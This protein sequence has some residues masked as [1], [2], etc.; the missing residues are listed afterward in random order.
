[1]KNLQE[2]LMIRVFP[3]SG[4]QYESILLSEILPDWN[5]ERLQAF[6]QANAMEW[7][8]W[9]AFTPWVRYRY[10]D[11][12][13]D[14]GGP[15]LRL[16]VE[17]NLGS[18]SNGLLFDTEEVDQKAK[19][20]DPE[21]PY[22]S[23]D[24]ANI[25]EDFGRN[26][27]IPLTYLPNSEDR[28]IEVSITIHWIR[29]TGIDP[30]EVDLVVDL[31][32]TRTVALLLE[33][34]S[35]EP[36]SFGRRV[37]PVRFMPP[38]ETFKV[39]NFNGSGI[40][41]DDLSIIDS[42]FVLKR[43][44]FA[45]MEPPYGE[46]KVLRVPKENSDPKAETSRRKILKYIANTFVEMSP[47]LIGGGDFDG[48][49]RKALA[50]A[51]LDE[52]ARFTMGSPKRYAWD[53]RSVGMSGSNYWSQM[54]NSHG[55]S[56]ERPFYFE[57][58]D[59][60]FRLFMDPEGQ[61]W[62]TNGTPR[63][64]DLAHAPFRNSP[65]NFPRRDSI[66]WFALSILEAA[67]RQ[68]NSD[69]Y[70]NV[71]K[72]RTLPRKLARVSVLYPSGWTKL[73]K[74]AYFNQWKRAMKIFTTSHLSGN[75]RIELE[76]RD[77]S[78]LPVFEER[79]LDEA[80]CA[81]LP[82]VYSE[83]C[84]LGGAGK[85]WFDLYGNGKKVRVM[86]VDIGGGTTDFSVIEYR[87]D[88]GHGETPETLRRNDPTARLSAKLWYK[89]GKSIAGDALV[90][91][92]IEDM[93]I[94]QWI[95]SSIGDLENLSSLERKWLS[96]MFSEPESILF[97]DV[98]SRLPSKLSRIARLVFLPIVNKILGKLG[99]SDST[100]DE[101]LI[102]ADSLADAKILD[103]LNSL[104]KE[105]LVRK[106]HDYTPDEHDLFSKDA[107]LCFSRAKLEERI[108]SVFVGLFDD[109]LQ[110][111]R[112][113]PC[114]MVILSGKPSELSRIKERI[115]EALP[116][117]PQRI[118]NLKGYEAGTWYPFA[119][120]GKVTDAKTAAVVGAALHQDILNGNL[121]GFSL[122]E[123]PHLERTPHYWGGI[124]RNA[125]PEEFFK[126][127]LFDKRDLESAR[128]S[129]VECEIP[130]GCILGRKSFRH[131]KSQPEP[132][133]QLCYDSEV[134]D[135]NLP[136]ALR[137]KLK[138]SMNCQLGEHLELIEVMQ[139]EELTAFDVARVALKLQTQMD[140]THWLDSPKLKVGELAH[141]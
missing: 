20:E 114:D 8:P 52:D 70:L 53:D 40:S 28:E 89:D 74:D 54:P 124:N 139:P 14:K 125:R 21:T 68:I 121:K 16:A 136:H 72:R 50:E 84:A 42:W 29:S 11:R 66:C 98:D 117:L 133:Y 64:S 49:A 44:N 119:E 130:L 122:K 93:L 103:G 80:M 108:D 96:K 109:L 87:P 69:N 35:H 126:N 62:E 15:L 46:E 129:F 24:E 59:G 45:E 37:Q 48:G 140:E 85:A 57:K 86:N 141:S 131:A 101:I 120:M 97:S 25:E 41:F 36:I 82:V 132:V 67:Y 77:R 128:E 110:V 106:I 60:L 137:V 88:A 4:H 91:K 58:L 10:E 19:M 26:R 81:Q 100:E 34:P 99:E 92:I 63:E 76:S 38:G 3:N 134:Q 73:E 105:T 127:L 47:A 112:E 94:P 9:D 83:V 78:C 102:K 138:W 22:A 30:V 7:K 17:T 107:T 61:D 33:H 90:K 31:G 116:I 123:E 32:N 71:A 113:F 43:S 65:P 13:F 104:A 95:S 23:Y 56:R 55:D 39:Q 18:A 5:K 51:P 1:M 79:G 115:H 75:G 135:E 111:F 2:N 6:A 12:S 118:I 27:C